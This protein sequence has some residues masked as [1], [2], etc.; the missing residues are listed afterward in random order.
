MKK[1]FYIVTTSKSLNLMD[2]QLEFLRNKGFKVG[3]IC[4]P[5]SELEE[6]NVD[7]KKAIKMEREI[8]PLKDIIS[9]FRLINY[10]RK[11]KPD[12]VN[13]GTPKAGLMGILASF[14]VRTPIRIY[15]LRGLRLET[16]KGLTRKILW[17]T[18]KIA[19]ILA[20][21]VIC[22]SPSLLEEAR[23]LKL[24]NSYKGKILNKGSSNGVQLNRFPNKNVIKNELIEL[25]KTLGI[26]EKKDFVLG[27]VGRLTKDKGIEELVQSFKI[28]QDKYSNI[29]LL[30]LGELEST[31]EISID[32]ENEFQ[33]NQGIIYLGYIK[34]PEK[35]YYLMDVFVFPTYR[36]GFG[37]VSAE[38]Q[39]AGTPVIVSNVTGAKDTLIDN[40]SGFLI[41][42]QNVDA[43]V[44]KVE[45][46]K[47]NRKLRNEMGRNGRKFI[48]ENFNSEKVWD[49]WHKYY[50]LEI[51]RIGK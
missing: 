28:L 42:S 13:V 5:G 20:T 27:Y 12:I 8:S 15:T 45:I 33:N 21:E 16:E 40:F 23:K 32:L 17:L 25:G 18:E 19:C 49:A 47:N 43:I 38:S 37:N 41:P 51:D 9:L 35:Y 46:L 4:S 1:I 36:E 48:E 26:D 7:F 22:I 39:A 10:L 50:S 30:I 3:A 14:F 34:N 2:G 6:L 44:E 24:I 29:K 11:E 31:N